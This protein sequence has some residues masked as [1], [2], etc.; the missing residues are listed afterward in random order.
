MTKRLLRVISILFLF[1]SGVFANQG[2]KDTYGYMWTDTKTPS[3]TTATYDWIDV[4]DTT[5]IFTY[6]PGNLDAVAS[7]SL[8][9]PFT[10]Y[11]TSYSTIW[12]SSNGFASFTDPAGSHPQNDSIPYVSGPATMLAAY[13]DDL[14]THIPGNVYFRKVGESPNRQVVVEW[15]QFEQWPAAPSTGIITFEIVLY[16]RTNLIK[17]QYHSLSTI[18]SDST[19]GGSATIG[20][21]SG[22]AGLLYSYNTQ[23]AIA[24]SSAILFHPKHLGNLADAAIS[25]A[26]VAAGTNFQ[27]LTYRIDN[28]DV[29]GD[30]SSLGKMDR[31]AIANPFAASTPIV[32]GIKINNYSAP[33]QNTTTAPARPGF[34]TWN[35]DPGTDSIFVQTSPFDVKDSLVINFMQTM[36]SALGT[37]NYQSRYDARLDSTANQV[38]TDVGWSVQVLGSTV[39]YY[40]FLPNTDQ[41]VS[42]GDTLTFTVTARDNYGNAVINSDDVVFTPV[43]ATGATFPSGSTLNFG[44]SS[45]VIVTVKDTVAES[46]SLKAQKSG[47]S[48][49]TGQSG[50][51]TV[52]PAAAFEIVKLTPDSSGVVGTTRTLRAQL[53]DQYGNG[54]SDSTLSFTI[55]SGGGSLSS[56]TA[57]TNVSGIGEVEYILGTDIELSPGMVE[58]SFGALTAQTFS[59]TLSPAVVSYYDFLPITAQSMSAGDSLTFTVTARD[60]YGN[61]VVSNDSIIFTASGLSTAY[62]SPRST[63]SF[64]GASTVTVAVKDTVADSF[65]IVGR[66]QGASGVT[67]QS[68]LITVNP[69]AAFEIVKLTP[70]SSGVVGTTRTLRAQLLDQYGNGLSDSTLSFTILSGGG[71]LSSGTAVTNVS[72]IGEVEYILGTDIELSPGMVEVS[73]GALTAQTFSVA[74]LPAAVSYYEFDPATTQSMSAGDSLTFTVTA[75]D[76][77]GNGVINSDDVIFSA[78]GSTSATFSPPPTVPFLNESTV[79]ITVKDTIAGSFRVKAEKATNAF[80]TGQSGIITVNPTT[81][82]SLVPVSALTNT[83]IVGHTVTITAELQDEFGNAIPDSSIL[84]KRTSTGN[85][86]FVSGGLDSVFSV[87]QSNGQASAAYRLST[88]TGFGSDTIQVRFGALTSLDFSFVL[89][90][91]SISYYTIVDNSSITPYHHTAGESFNIV[92]NGF[93]VYNNAATTSSRQV[94]LN[95]TA[96]GVNITPPATKNLASGNA[97]FAA[98][99]T[100]KQRNLTFRI[101]DSFGKSAISAPFTIVA[102]ALDSLNIMSGPDSSGISYSGSVFDYLT[103]DSTLSMYA[104][105]FDVYGNYIADI[106]SALWSTTGSLV[107]ASTDLPASH[108][109]FSPTISGR[110]GYIKVLSANPLIK[111]DSTGTITV[112]DGD[113]AYVLITT[114]SLGTN[115]LTSRT[116]L[117]GDTVRLYASGYDGAGN[118]TGLVS[119]DWSI[120]PGSLG[121]FIHLP[122]E[123]SVATANRITFIGDQIGSGT[124]DIVFNL[125][126]DISGLVT[127]KKGAAHHIVI[128]DQGNGGGSPYN[129][130]APVSI[131]TDDAIELYAAHYDARN[132]YLGDQPV[133]W[134]TVS[135]AG[136]SLVGVP[137]GPA[138]YITFSPQSTGTGKIRTVSATLINDTTTTITVT[139]GALAS[140]V[141]EDSTGAAVLSDTV[142]AGASRRWFS[143]GYDRWGNLRGRTPSTWSIVGDNIGVLNPIHADSTIFGGRTV[144]TAFIRAISDTAS[145]VDVTSDIR[146]V[147]GVPDSL[148]K[149]AETDAQNGV[150]GQ[151][152]ALPIRVEVH[153]NYGNP[154][155]GD[156]IGWLPK[157]GGSVSGA[158][159]VTNSLGIAQI[160]WTLHNDLS[161]DTIAAYV[162]NSPTTPDTIYFTAYPQAQSSRFMNYVNLNDTLMTGRIGETLLPFQV[163]ITDSLNNPANNAD[164][165]FVITQYPDGASGQSLTSYQTMTNPSGVA[166]TRLVLGNKLG[167]YEVTSFSNASGSPLIF[168]GEAVIPDTAASIA[169]V[170]GNNQTGTVKQPLPIPVQVKLLDRFN[171]PLADSTLIFEPLNGGTVSAETVVTNSQGIAQTVWTPDSIAQTYYLLARLQNSLKIVSDT[172][173]AV[174]NPAAAQNLSIVSLRGIPA[175]GVSAPPHG[176]VPF[177]VKVADLYGNPV[178]NRTVKSEVV[179]PSKAV[180][181]S[182]SSVSNSSGDILNSVEIDDTR[183]STLIRT[184][185]AGIDTVLIKIYRLSYVIGSLTPASAALG[186]T[187]SFSVSISNPGP[188]QVQLDTS[189]QNS[190]ITF[191]DGTH[192][193]KAGLQTDRTAGIIT[194]I[195][196]GP[197]VL[198]SMFLVASYEPDIVLRGAGT[199]SLMNGSFFTEAN[200]FSVAS[201]EIASVNVISPA[202]GQVKRGDTLRVRMSINNQGSVPIRVD[203]S[204]T[205]PLVSRAGEPPLAAMFSKASIADSLVNPGTNTID[206]WWTVPGDFALG[207]YVLDGKFQGEVVGSGSI[208]SASGAISPS[209]FQVIQAARIHY[210]SGPLPSRVTSGDSAELSI[211]LSNAGQTNVVLTPASTFLTFDADTFYLKTSQT[212]TAGNSQTLNFQKGPVISPARLSTRQIFVV[213]AGEEYGVPFTATVDTN[214]AVINIDNIPGNVVVRHLSITP[215][216]ASQDQDS[217][218]VLFEVYNPGPLN[219]PV[220]VQNLSDIVLQGPQQFN[221]FIDNSSAPA[222]PVTIARG[223]SQ[224]FDYFISIPS[225][226]PPGTDSIFASLDYSDSNTGTVYNRAYPDSGAALQVLPRASLQIDTIF[227]TPQVVSQGQSGVQISMVVTNTGEVAGTISAAALQF[228]NNH[229]INTTPLLPRTV[230]PAAPETLQY[231]ITINSSAALGEDPI[232]GSLTYSDSLNGKSYDYPLTEKGSLL[233]QSFNQAL[234]RINSVSVNELYVNQGHQGNILANVSITNSGQASISLQ[235]LQLKFSPDTLGQSLVSTLPDVIGG[236]STKNYTVN[237]QIPDSTVPGTIHLDAKI[238]YID[239]NSSQSYSDS[240]AVV[241]DSLIIQEPAVI[242][243]HKL[244]VT[245]DTVSAGKTGLTLAFTA[246]NTGQA[247]LNLTLS[248]LSGTGVNNLTR[249]SPVGL[250]AIINGGD[251]SSFVYRGNA[252]SNIGSYPI[253]FLLSGTDRNDGRPVGPDSSATPAVLTVRQPGALFIDS[254]VVAEPTVFIGQQ[255]VAATVYIRNSGQMP[256]TIDNVILGF[257]PSLGFAQTLHSALG[258]TVAGGNSVAASF[259]FSLLSTAQTGTV[260]VGAQASGTEIDLQ[261]SRNATA[262]VSALDTF[263]VIPGP[264]LRI[265][266]VSSDYD[267]VSLGQSGISVRVKLR[268]NGGVPAVVDT[269]ALKFSQG[270]F[271]NLVIT[272]ALSLPANS[273]P[274]V[275]TFNNVSVNPASQTGL[276]TINARLSATVGGNVLKVQNA[277]TSY[278]WRIV[279]KGSLQPVNYSPV[280]I[281]RGNNVTFTAQIRNAGQANIY[282]LPDVTTLFIGGFGISITDTVSVPGGQQRAVVFPQS[283]INL[284]PGNYPVSLRMDQ[285]Q[286]NGGY[287]S[288]TLNFTGTLR[289]DSPVSLD[290]SAVTYPRI[291][292]QN[293]TLPIH[294]TLSNGG[295]SAP[296]HIDSITI[297][298]LGY[299]NA[300]G[301]LLN[302]GGTHSDSLV[303]FIDTT[304]AGTLNNITVRFYWTDQN[305][306]THASQALTLQPVTIHRQAKLAIRDINGPTAVYAGQN[307]IEVQVSIENTGETTAEIDAADLTHHIGPYVITPLQIP[308][309]IRAGEQLP[310]VFRVDIDANTAT[311]ADFFGAVAAYHD[312]LNQLSQSVSADS[313][314]SW[315][316][317]QEAGAEILSVTSPEVEVTQGQKN[318]PVTVRVRNGGGQPLRVD[319]LSLISRHAGD[320][321]Y[322]YYAQFVPPVTVNANETKLFEFLVDVRDVAQ[323]GPDSLDARLAGIVNF[324]GNVI[325]LNVDSATT[326][327]P[328]VIKQK[329]NLQVEGIQLAPER[330]SK[331]QDFATL[332]TQIRNSA[333]GAPMAAAV[334]DSVKILINGNP[335]DTANFDLQRQTNLPLT[336]QPGDQADVNFRIRPRTNAESGNYILQTLLYYHAP[337]VDSTMQVAGVVRD[338][339]IVEEPAVFTFL[340]IV[341]NRDTTH[342]G[343]QNDSL[344]IVLRN[345][346][347]AT[348]RINNG[349]ILI[350]GTGEP[351]QTVLLSPPLPTDLAGGSSMQFNYALN[352]PASPGFDALAS[353]RAIVSG[354]DQNSGFS[355]QDTSSASG[356]AQVQILTP[357]KIGFV[358]GSLNPANLE[359]QSDITFR[360]VVRNTGSSRIVLIPDSTKF[361]V[362]S[363][364]DQSTTLQSPAF[365]DAHDTTTLKFRPVSLSLQNGTYSTQLS[366]RGVVHGEAYS[367]DLI[368]QPLDVGAAITIPDVYFPALSGNRQVVLGDTAITIEMQVR[369]FTAQKL[370]LNP[371]PAVTGLHIRNTTTNDL[372]DSTFSLRR[373]D[374]VT[375]LKELD[376]VTLQFKIDIPL[377]DVPVGGYK[378]QGRVQTSAPSVLSYQTVDSAASFR[379]I[380]GAKLVYD[381]LLPNIGIAGQNRMFQTRIGNDALSAVQLNAANTVLTLSRGTDILATNLQANYVLPGKDS[382]GADIKYTTISFQ[383]V[384]IPAG[385]QPGSYNLQLHLEG[386]LQT[387]DPFTNFDTT[388]SGEFTLRD[389]TV[390]LASS[391]SGIPD[392]MSQGQSNIPATITIRNDGP[393]TGEVNSINLIFTNSLGQNVSSQWSVA[394]LDTLS[395]LQLRSQDSKDLPISLGITAQADTGRIFLK[396]RVTYQDSV[397]PEKIFSRLSD[398]LKTVTVLR[399]GQIRIFATSVP[400]DSLPNFP[401]V[402]YGQR[403]PISV[404]LQNSGQEA[405]KNIKV[406]LLLNDIPQQSINRLTLGERSDTTIIF[407]AVAP[408]Q[409]GTAIFRTRLDSAFSQ[410]TGGAVQIAPALD[411]NAVV[412]VQSPANLQLSVEAKDT[413]SAGQTFDLSATVENIGQA[414]I[415]NSGRLRLVLPPSA[416]YNSADPDTQFFTQAANTV[417]WSILAPTTPSGPSGDIISVYYVQIPNDINIDST[418]SLVNQ[419]ASVTV[420]TVSAARIESIALDITHPQGAMDSTLSSGQQF[421][422][423]AKVAFTL[424]VADTGRRAQITLPPGFDLLN[425]SAQQDL[426]ED[427]AVWV[428]KVPDTVAGSALS[429]KSGKSGGNFLAPGNS[430][431][432]GNI[433][434]ELLSGVVENIT[435]EA[436]A[437]DEHSGDR[438]QSEPK[439][440]PVTVQPRA[441]LALQWEVA[442]PEGAID[443]E[444]STWQ[445]FVIH[446]WIQNG[447]EA[448][449]TGLNTVK[450][451]LPGGYYFRKYDH[452]QADSLLQVATDSLNYRSLEIF[453]DTVAHV[454][455][456]RIRIALESAASDENTN[457][458]AVIAGAIGTIQL[459]TVNR[460]ALVLSLD[461]TQINVSQSETFAVTGLLQNTGTANIEPGDSVRVALRID[462]SRLAFVNPADS[463]KWASLVNKQAPLS[464]SLVSKDL[465]GNAQ[466]YATI[467]QD[468]EPA[469]YDENNYPDSLVHRVNS[470]ANVQVNVA[471]SGSISITNLEILNANTDTVSTGQLFTLRATVNLSGSVN[472]TGRTA[473]IINLPA[474]FSIQGSTVLPLGPGSSETASWQIRAPD[475]LS[476]QILENLQKIASSGT[477]G[478][479]TA[480]KSTNNRLSAPVEGGSGGYETDALIDFLES[481][482][483]VRARGIESNTGATL[484]DIEQKMVT[485]QPRSRI[486]LTAEINQPAGAG[487][488]TVSTLQKFELEMTVHRDASSA[489]TTDSSEVQITLPDGFSFNQT[490][491]ERK[492]TVQ[493]F[494]NRTVVNSIYTSATAYPDRQTI[495]AQIINAAIDINSGQPAF[496]DTGLVRFTDMRIVE[497]ANLHVNVLDYPDTLALNQPFEI[498]AIVTNTGTAGVSPGNKIPVH[499]RYDASAFSLSQGDTL[500][501]MRIGDTLRWNLQSSNSGGSHDFTISLPKILN[502]TLYYDENNYATVPVFKSDS[503]RTFGIRVLDLG[504]FSIQSF[505]FFSNVNDTSITVS[506]NQDSIP[507]EVKV[508][509]NPLFTENRLA[510]LTLPSGVTS[511]SNQQQLI[512]SDSSVT[513]YLKAPG[514]ATQQDKVIR[515]IT[516]STSPVN[517]LTLR[518]T[519]FVRLRAIT[520]A[521]LAL[522]AEITEPAGARDDTVSYGQTFTYQATVR[523]TGQAGVTGAASLRLTPGSSLQLVNQD[524]VKPF[525]VDQPVTWTVRV[526]SNSQVNALM[527]RVRNLQAKQ[528]H[529]QTPMEGMPVEGSAFA[530]GAGR[531]KQQINDLYDEIVNI[532]NASMLAVTYNQIPKDSLTNQTASTTVTQVQTPIVIQESAL[533]RIAG[534]QTQPR[535]S[536]GQLFTVQTE[537]EAS[538]QVSERRSAV[539]RITGMQVPDSTKSFTGTS[540]SWQIQAPAT[541]DGPTTIP[542]QVAVA[543]TD[544]NSGQALASDSSGN[545]VLERKAMLSLRLRIKGRPDTGG[546]HRLSFDQSFTVVAKIRNK[547]DAQLS[548]QGQLRLQLN[549]QDSIALA[550]GETQVKSFTYPDSVSWDLRTPRQIIS[551]GIGAQFVQ[552]PNDV[553]TAQPAALDPD[554]SSATLSI[555]TE[556]HRLVVIPL[557][558]SQQ[559]N[560][561]RQQGTEDVPLIGLVFDNRKVSEFV[562]T[563]TIDSL[564]LLVQQLDGSPVLNPSSLI[565]SVKIVNRA[566]LRNLQ[567]VGSA[568][569]VFAAYD[570]TSA[571]GDEIPLEFTN[572]LNIIPGV[573]DSLVVLLNLSR[574]SPNQS[575]KLHV[576]SIRAFTGS[577]DNPVEIVDEQGNLFSSGGDV[578]GSYALT[579]ISGDK[580]KI[581]G[582][583]PNPFGMD[584]ASTNFVFWME[585]NGT[586]EIRIYTLLGGLVYSQQKSFTGGQLYDGHNNNGLIW[587][588]T[589]NAGNRVLNGVYIAILN[590]RYSDGQSKSYKTKVAYIK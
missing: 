115:E 374:T 364:P 518:D 218:R 228:L 143:A 380:S 294:Y 308:T 95:S 232:K 134:D 346:G 387:G 90:P 185:I 111:G 555:A 7:I 317:Y 118:F 309:R 32:T 519:A 229:T 581:F 410:L 365:I 497:R 350:G 110:S 323:A 417:T 352:Y 456:E 336:I 261:Q 558:F 495:L 524:P 19:S 461:S 126:S 171:N 535:I 216:T 237:I 274:Q 187:F 466:C 424:G 366:L 321:N 63:L 188:I 293:M 265:L 343:K 375:V 357:P 20:V 281:T 557:E 413:V 100:K 280:A 583:H 590:I 244:T 397:A 430:P 348:A 200:A 225:S 277:D 195:T 198:D 238:G 156:S 436:S 431:E 256:V 522:S 458:P 488:H 250:P 50:L 264:Q 542:L 147:A 259:T 36:P 93:D 398:T 337:K 137:A 91:D 284:P 515:V 167:R 251:S 521:T 202:S 379:V 150:A 28:I 372:Y 152:L 116:M 509:L 53:L 209:T 571:D 213:L 580:D 304:Y 526:D 405:L 255:D 329:P 3:S 550:S 344:S 339:V 479:R 173:Q 98:V 130:M 314:H 77:Y 414:A 26:S 192:I 223:G 307:N 139:N 298:S 248:S 332:S 68:G 94:T 531:I 401:N 586:A 549:P 151:S 577:H 295:N 5:A 505:H 148:F 475:T 48:G 351:I 89:K 15:H 172:L 82:L 441:S 253:N 221:Y 570:V 279:T 504:N 310:F 532:V 194:P 60:N 240:L 551:T 507:L 107:P 395:Q 242:N 432:G 258:D 105:G 390:I 341:P 267:S 263:E 114:D 578:G 44:G 538:S 428:I 103:T 33:I 16:E 463:L 554:S 125:M 553:N 420:H 587:N 210:V 287:Y 305:A 311:G 543:A 315:S 506:T 297:A 368:G 528:Q 529:M 67:G 121:K 102:G 81:N 201:I 245:P 233:I 340:S 320:S 276:A 254:V 291:I 230:S 214:A 64:D 106:T 565:D 288:A 382:S 282:L 46:F 166:E 502:D 57:V 272:P 334:L 8:P 43:G 211:Q 525:V 322:R 80:V 537:I 381:S 534:I 260:T 318:I 588:G 35:Y 347:E 514:T 411:D 135:V 448:G 419:Q 568:P 168:A 169:I 39:S 313:L 1:I 2:G 104:A 438:I 362:L 217:L 442:E 145:K 181:A 437:F 496:V 386:T 328:W 186:E 179:Q 79:T 548:G 27:S 422:L 541:I 285:Y 174:A 450:I 38:S 132:N 49:V 120:T 439:T 489:P 74:V 12:V 175:N 371:D 112:Q 572:H 481:T 292:S 527:S 393:S 361:S 14:D 160:F 47:V 360:M 356:A 342:W 377:L 510:T 69:A 477:K 199:D 324:G 257:N 149:I 286:E 459:K 17:F 574:Q 40:D 76:N 51:I 252:A 71:S 335:N 425:G 136:G 564:S 576:G 182:G 546:G 196:F 316:I 433:P 369:N 122:G 268:N 231:T 42:A 249:L 472:A 445:K 385:F 101:A 227:A 88:S 208:I 567:K 547:G 109:T 406:E 87:T 155:P 353:Y 404:Q 434:N 56:G 131:T 575:F 140:I 326:V 367:R 123:D 471:T 563:V 491:T 10:F 325:P 544:A 142:S 363:S 552:V 484:E 183:D 389:T 141:I 462:T 446:T 212:I 52:S 108:F 494:E 66:K 492:D 219:A 177:V 566:Y 582:N 556:V 370:E 25:P 473:E 545:F 283:L 443:L 330:M 97:V 457:A 451:S 474:E 559:E 355:L 117:A 23:G 589:N 190:Y 455:P 560:V 569:T 247:G 485:V 449:T 224:Q 392:F 235:K 498:S 146:V 426:V 75:R 464:W 468:V 84:F 349:S 170:A 465:T 58:V 236:N 444:V 427:S 585:K 226:Y 490:T 165:S 189:N 6:G 300:N 193:Y 61:G 338:T 391:I 561:I 85:G 319:T 153:D 243:V 205:T 302:G 9:F 523:N 584:E 30:T 129:A 493:I 533:F 373:V 271:A 503:T 55:L 540:V 266:S 511:T 478:I 83:G 359:V 29:A 127:V 234:V 239:L 562:P 144:G 154:V 447:G 453:T 440:L 400:V 331:G 184:Y 423:R 34:A 476:Q 41:N 396:A 4:T 470:R 18:P 467:D 412:M 128:R 289:V 180:L 222:F 378:V 460:A 408:P 215:S 262:G 162:K 176:S 407:T 138:S 86:S 157:K 296:A 376:Q 358:A 203:D 499:L 384:P 421:T 22:N 24:P 278:S 539:L 301:Y 78:V 158:Y 70:D 517:N 452:T 21:Q 327:Q 220:Q 270:T 299:T 530:A 579:V 573:K 520:R 508:N 178:P 204:Q 345:D 512:P 486:W 409:S 241:R 306:S 45:A 303:P 435:V 73:F 480:G 11:G 273:S 513:W 54:L 418:A 119:A 124:I 402:N 161:P 354:T 72:G 501:S 399:P 163:R 206:Y 13:W 516:E 65:T 500:H 275:V 269:V 469:A 416:G 62:F 207:E 246:R 415:D 96:P 312:S 92:V 191:S 133:P 31:L 99:V 113:T 487:D 388:A 197:D 536:T 454:Q 483:T 394:G 482:L 164:V 403:F 159:S 383:E 59:V 37:G 429:G 290:T 333:G